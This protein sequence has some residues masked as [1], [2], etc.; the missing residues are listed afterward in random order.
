[1]LRLRLMPDAAPWAC[2]TA[3][4]LVIC[5]PQ[6]SL[7][8]SPWARAHASVCCICERC[9]AFCLRCPARAPGVWGMGAAAGRLFTVL[10]RC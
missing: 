8:L 2:G 3:E 1:M 10:C 4:L 6:L 7:L 9:A 5:I